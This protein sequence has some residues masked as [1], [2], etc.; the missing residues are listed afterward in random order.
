V[1][2]NVKGTPGFLRVK[3]ADPLIIRTMLLSC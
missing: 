1:S 3:N 2:G